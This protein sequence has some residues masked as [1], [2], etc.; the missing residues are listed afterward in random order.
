[1]D[2]ID[3]PDGRP[4]ARA[5]GRFAARAEVRGA[6]PAAAGLPFFLT[7]FFRFPAISRG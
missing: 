5:A 3:R 4:A 7:V 6:G 1:M 2:S